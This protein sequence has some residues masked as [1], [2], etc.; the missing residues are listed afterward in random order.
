MNWFWNHY[1][2]PGGSPLD[3]LAAPLLA[4]SCANLPNALIVTAQVDPLRREGLSFAR[5]LADDGVEVVL[6]DFPGLIHGY[7]MMDR[8]IPEASTTF[9]AMA[10][11]VQGVSQGCQR[12]S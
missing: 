11:F 6:H 7:L 10:N 12:H 4:N 3:Q 2:G 1:L 9:E 8:A 5:R